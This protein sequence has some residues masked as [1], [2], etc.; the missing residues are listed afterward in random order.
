MRRAATLIAIAALLASS[1]FA[2]PQTPPRVEDH[3]EPDG[4]ILGGSA[5]MASYD[6]MLRNVLHTAYEPEVVLRMVAQPSFIPEYAVGLR[7]TSQY[8]RGAPYRIFGLTPA[9]SVWTYQSIAMLTRGEVRMVGEKSQ[10]LQKKE[11][12]R[13]Q[14][15]V[16]TDPHDLKVTF[17]ETSIG[18][19][20][21]G[22]IV[23]VWRK[24][25]MRTRYSAQYTA[26]TD[27]ANYDFGMM[28]PGLG[29]ISG[30]VW[31]PDRNSSTGALVTLA[32]QMYGLCAKK[33]N[34]SME[35]LEKITAELEHRLQ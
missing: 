25:L 9:T 2:Q 13:L 17:C 3:L 7:R 31:L 8:S 24:M 26:G 21:G 20:L 32:D 1:A 6:L 28:V 5:F 12:A 16:P 10:D 14:A 11:I 34:A 33:K 27:G 15:S 4:S 22:R 35:Q 19:G 29:P 18:D 23:E 30:K